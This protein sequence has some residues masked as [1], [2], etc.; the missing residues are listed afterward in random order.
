MHQVCYD[1][2]A[3]M[4]MQYY[5]KCN[6]SHYKIFIKQSIKC[7]VFAIKI[8]RTL[9]TMCCIGIDNNVTGNVLTSAR[10]MRTL[11]KKSNLQHQY[12]PCFVMRTFFLV[13]FYTICL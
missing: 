13:P 8:K 9:T 10:S 1:V 6:K 2:T 12:N 11:V 7:F 4:S 3:A 5:E